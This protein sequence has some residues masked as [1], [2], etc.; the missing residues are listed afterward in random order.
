M[1]N[2]VFN[3]EP[4]GVSKI[5]LVAKCR[6]FQ[7]MQGLLGRPHKVESSVSMDSLRV[8]AGAIGGAVAEISNANVRDLSQ[9]CDEFKF[10]ELAKTVRD[11]QV[12]HPQIDPVIRRGPDLARPALEE[13]FESQA[14]T[15]LML[16][17][18]VHRG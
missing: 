14:R 9:L 15:M 6:P 16:D 3:G 11:W 7:M 1:Y 10:I 18:A 12:E 4:V 8:F 13:R 17:Q 2:L 5:P